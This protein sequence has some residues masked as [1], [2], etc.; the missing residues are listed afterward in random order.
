M[1]RPIRILVLI[2]ALAAAGRGWAQQADAATSVKRSAEQLGGMASPVFIDAHSDLR[3]R[4]K[5]M[6][7]YAQGRPRDAFHYFQLA[8]RYADKAS[9][10]LV[11]VMYWTG[12]GVSR[13]RPLGY[14]W[15]DLAASRGYPEL[16][17]QQQIYWN[18]LTDAERAKAL[19][20]RATL[21][22]EYGDLVGSRRLTLDIG[23]ARSQ[24]TGSRV[25]WLG[26]G[27]A[28]YGNGAVE[29]FS[30]FDKAL[31]MNT[32]EYLQV[33]DLQWQLQMNSRVHVG[34]PEPVVPPRVNPSRPAA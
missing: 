34:E 2:L 6:E 15:I 29:D 13:D 33:K 3:Y 21:D 25:G 16:K 31:H 11:A 20:L 14:A 8:S 17:R 1:D 7:A 10:A 12:D 28:A 19:A 5:G 30:K 22:G 24:V 4:S 23:S 32:A 26:A 18:Q 27:S 9:Q